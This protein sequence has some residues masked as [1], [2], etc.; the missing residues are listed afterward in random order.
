MLQQDVTVLRQG[1]ALHA[2]DIGM[3]FQNNAFTSN[4]DNDVVSQIFRRICTN[5]YTWKPKNI[6][7]DLETISDSK[8]FED[9]RGHG[10]CTD[11]RA[12]GSQ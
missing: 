4:N 8:R 5:L 2:I 3:R 6:Y 9:E 7:K 10:Q 1:T 12:G 11:D